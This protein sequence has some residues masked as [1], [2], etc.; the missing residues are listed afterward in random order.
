MNARA[1]QLL[2][3][4]FALLG[5]VNNQRMNTSFLTVFDDNLKRRHSKDVVKEDSQPKYFKIAY[6]LLKTFTGQHTSSW[7][8]HLLWITL[9][10]GLAPGLA[11]GPS[12]S[13]CMAFMQ[14]TCL[15][16]KPDCST[17]SFYS[18][19]T[20]AYRRLDTLPPFYY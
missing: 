14:S 2:S 4:F 6:Q 12:L 10:P 8:Q 11:P 17:H 7:I 9:P 19:F 3:F 1:S 15:T 20:Q 16:R 5:S 13:F 18:H